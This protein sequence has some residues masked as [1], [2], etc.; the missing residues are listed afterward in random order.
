MIELHLILRGYAANG[1]STFGSGRAANFTRFGYDLSNTERPFTVTTGGLT[2]SNKSSRLKT[3][4]FSSQL[5]ASTW[6]LPSNADV[7]KQVVFEAIGAG[8][9]GANGDPGNLGAGGGGGGAYA[10]VTISNASLN[11]VFAITVPIS[12]IATAQDAVVTR[13]SQS[14]LVAKGGSSAST[15]TGGTGGSSGSCVGDV[16]Y[17]G[18]NASNAVGTLGG[19]GGASAN[20]TGNGANASG[21]TAGVATGIGGSGGSRDVAGSSPGGGAGGSADSGSAKAGGAG[22]VTITYY[23]F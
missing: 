5:T 9:Y 4:S 12:V 14:F 1:T 13:N 22:L 15:I 21:G 3:I 11:D 16:A 18:G 19:T 17:S 2:T 6:R 8:G 10:K 23:E 7:S 20:A